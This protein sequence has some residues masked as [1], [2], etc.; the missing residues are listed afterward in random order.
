MPTYQVARGKYGVILLL[1]S[2]AM[3][4]VLAGHLWS[5]Q[6]GAGWRKLVVDGFRSSV[7]AVTS[8]L[9]YFFSFA[10]CFPER[11]K[12]FRKPKFCPR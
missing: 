12:A 9:Q 4:F 3:F 6:A 8:A 5:V 10:T 7:E 2:A 1:A 11:Q